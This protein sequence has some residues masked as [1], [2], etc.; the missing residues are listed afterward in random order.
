MAP[1]LS[2]AISCCRCC[3]YGTKA[4]FSTTTTVRQQLGQADL[5]AA[6]PPP[7]GYVRLT[8]RALISLAGQDST[9]FLQG[10]VTQNMIMGKEPIRT[11]RRTGSYAAFLNSHG[12]V[13]HDV[14]I[15]PVT[16]NNGS[17][18]PEEPEWLIE[19]DKAEVK[20]LLKHLK[21]HKLRSKFTIRELDESERSIWASWNE[22]AEPRWAAY[23]IESDLPSQ[24]SASSSIVGCMDTRAPGFGA[25]LLTPGTDDLRTHFPDCSL[26]GG[27]EVDLTTYNLRRILHGVAEGQGE[28]IRESALPMESNMD[29]ARA[30]DFRKGCYVGQELTIRT[31]HTGVVRK[32]ILPVQLYDNESNAGSSSE[33]PVYD[34]TTNL[35]IPPAGAN[36]SRVSARKGRSAGKFLGGIG[37]VGLALCRL[38]MMTDIKLT[39]ESS[40][41]DPSQE[42]KVSLDSEEGGESSSAGEVKVRAILPAWLRMYIE[43]GGARGSHAAASEGLRAK[44]LVEQLEG[45]TEHDSRHRSA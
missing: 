26:L 15:Y 2:A 37:N 34:P 24:L 10:M 3:R 16:G 30:I 14:F 21:K 35:P 5:P 33:K 13:L 44:D 28:I 17:G 1:R 22:N 27:K 45:E 29:A 32:R 31:H 19:V 40:Q 12:R 18:S 8:N 43:A 6:P 7:A 42:F 38:E 20:N 36:I 11:A 23:N 4:S 25:R 39:G 41:Y 9:S